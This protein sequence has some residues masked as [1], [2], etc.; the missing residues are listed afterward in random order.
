MNGLT[1]LDGSPVPPIAFGTWLLGETAVEAIGS[2]IDAGYRVFDTAAEYG[3]E[4]ALGAAIRASGI[5]R[6]QIFVSTKLWIADL[7]YDSALRAF[8][9]SADALGLDVVDLYLVHWPGLDDGRIVESWRALRRLHAEGRARHIGV[10]NFQARHLDML[11]DEVPAVN[12]IEVHPWFAQPD[13][14]GE[15]AAR[16]IPVMSWGPL[17]HGALLDDPAL[18][19]IADAHHASVAQIVL[20]WHLGRGFLPVVKSADAGRLRANLNSV[21]VRLSDAELSEIGAL[22]RHARLGGDPDRFA[23]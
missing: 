6:D 18:I 13:L 15:L 21:G 14:V 17:G 5:E 23:G 2:A 4:G 16:G 7:G 22:D 3:T 12:Q 11:G 9:A 20:A 19:R 1:L 8:D 10:S